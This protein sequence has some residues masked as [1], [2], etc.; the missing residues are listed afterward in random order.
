MDQCNNWCD[1]E[2]AKY[3]KYITIQTSLLSVKNRDYPA[4]IKAFIYSDCIVHFF[5][6]WQS[7]YFNL[8]MGAPVHI[9]QWAPCCQ[10]NDCLW[11][12]FRLHH[13]FQQ[14]TDHSCATLAPDSFCTPQK[15][16]CWSGG[17]SLHQYLPLSISL[18]LIP[19]I[20]FLNLHYLETH[21]FPSDFSSNFTVYLST[22]STFLSCNP[23]IL[24]LSLS[25][26]HFLLHS[27][28][29]KAASY[30][31]GSWRHN[32]DWR[33][34]GIKSSHHL[35]LKITSSIIYS[36]REISMKCFHSKQSEIPVQHD[37]SMEGARYKVKTVLNPS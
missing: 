27:R 17:K 2:T 21:I 24:S 12:A 11:D 20:T 8:Q 14:K 1:N 34:N 4:G 3:R 28:H 13:G 32:S 10:P 15:Q 9:Y 22:F 23:R 18:C 6:P 33:L 36:H 19:S 7:V 31:S 5:P 26:L 16:Q 29:H 25:L 35:L 30:S 37:G